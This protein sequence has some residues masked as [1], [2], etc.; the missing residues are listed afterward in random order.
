[1]DTWSFISIINTRGELRC[2]Y[3]WHL[4][5]RYNHSVITAHRRVLTL[6]SWKVC[7]YILSVLLQTVRQIHHTARVLWPRPTHHHSALYRGS[8]TSYAGGS[9]EPILPDRRTR[10]C[11]MHLWTWSI[12]FNI[13]FIPDMKWNVAFST[14]QMHC[15]WIMCMQEMPGCIL[16]HETWAYWTYSTTQNALRL[17]NQSS[18]GR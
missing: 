14:L 18:D 15:I 5:I 11:T 1:M 6:K 3:L 8:N 2:P 4:S 13:L 7:L 10:P 9:C 17:F 12:S 16:E